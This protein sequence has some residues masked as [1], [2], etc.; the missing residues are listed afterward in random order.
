M[1]VWQDIATARRGRPAR[2]QKERKTGAEGRNERPRPGP[3][4]PPAVG[5]RRLPLF[6]FRFFDLRIDLTPFPH[7]EFDLAIFLQR[8]QNVEHGRG[9]ER[10]RHE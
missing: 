4:A 3:P 6:V 1:I 8:S 5:F 7:L 9:D 2:G 10:R